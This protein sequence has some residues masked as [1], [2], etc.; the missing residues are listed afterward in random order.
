MKKFYLLLSVLI[1][2]ILISKTYSQSIKQY[3]G[4]Y[5][6]GTGT[7]GKANYSYYEK[8]GA[9]IK[10][11]S[12]TYSN[13]V[14]TT[15]GFYNISINGNYKDNY[16]NG[17]W[18]YVIS[19]KD[20]N[21]G[22]GNIYSTGNIKLTS[23]YANGYP[24]GNWNYSETNQARS[25][26]L[27]G[28]TEY[29]PSTTTIASANFKNGLLVG[30]FRM[31][32]VIDNDDISGTMDDNGYCINEWVFTSG[33]TD[34]KETKYQFY[35]KILISYVTTSVSTGQEIE[36]SNFSENE[37]T[38][39]K[40]YADGLISN[41][42]LKNAGIKIDTNTCDITLSSTFYN[43]NFISSYITGDKSYN[44]N[45]FQGKGNNKYGFQIKGFY[46]IIAARIKFTKLFEIREYNRAIEYLDNI[47]STAYQLNKS[48]DDLK[49][50]LKYYEK[51]LSSTDAQILKSKIS[52]CENKME[53]KKNQEIEKDNEYKAIKEFDPSKSD[54]ETLKIFLVRVKAYN[55]K[56][57]E[58]FYNSNSNSKYPIEANIESY[59]ELRNQEVKK[60]ELESIYYFDAKKQDKETL[61]K[62]LQQINSF[63]EKYN[64]ITNDEKVILD[65]KTTIIEKALKKYK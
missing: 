44:Y 18:T 39:I 62:A 7:P 43:S 15:L 5:S 33:K 6:N 31:K 55:E 2:S 41:S 40:N 58:D 9:S 32:G 56:Y 65:D 24:D 16:K 21:T 25:K 17:A 37:V 23:N 14:K 59:I 19:Y 60:S 30:N 51:S 29:Y 11:G 50:V 10:H 8:D 57:P 54:L 26:T 28:W 48:L 47:N 64:D 46:M 4:E 45:E 53:N 36:K 52:E 3:S 38:L 12:F 49:F 42:D 27:S 35:K 63:K 1:L 34:I 20:F 61:L 22:M 13:I